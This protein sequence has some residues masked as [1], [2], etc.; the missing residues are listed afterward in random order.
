V[1]SN[2]LL[3]ARAAALVA[4]GMVVGAGVFKSPALVAANVGSDAA[5]FGAW[6]LGG[7]LAVVGAACYGELAAAFPSRGGDYRFL[8]LAY[9]ARIGFLFAWA[10]Y[11]VI[12]TGS[13]ALLAFVL[14]DYLQAAVS[15]GTYGSSIYAMAT[16]VIMSA[17]NLKSR[18]AGIET[19]VGLTLGLVAG[20]L[21]VGAAGVVLVA[22]GIPPLAPSPAAPGGW[23]AFG[24]AMVF[25]ML[26]YGGWS[27]IATLSAEMRDGARGMLRALVGGMALVAMLYLV[28]NWALWRGLGLAGLAASAAPAAEL[29]SLALPRGAEWLVI[30]VVFAAVITSINA[31]ILV[32]AR[33]TFAAARDWPALA[34][35]ASWD[36]GRAVPAPALLAQTAFALVLVGLGTATRQGFATLVDFTAPVYWLFMVL[37]GLAVIVLRVRRAG[38]AR[39]FRVPLYP[40][41]PLL[42][43]TSSLFVLWSS[44]AY[45]RVGALAGLGVLGLGVAL[46]LLLGRPQPAPD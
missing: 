3:S 25:V 40:L 22:R 42:F 12:N 16:L 9:G 27:E 19:Q 35:L 32:G 34:R 37:S 28:I 4:V 41:L 44:I 2:G 1:N 45:V 20:I 46:S 43:A 18:T 23:G 11:A 26:A 17:V 31:T 15:L 33:T 24:V 29:I 14:G 6:L 7:V 39:P 30:G 13:L 10:R 8:S 5:L 38:V 21:L 36:D